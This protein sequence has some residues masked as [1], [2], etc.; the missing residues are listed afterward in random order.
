[1]K[2]SQVSTLFSLFV[3]FWVYSPFT[4]AYT[5]KTE[6]LNQLEKLDDLELISTPEE[7]HTKLY[8]AFDSAEK[9]IHIGIFGISS[10]KMADELI[11]QIHRGIDVIIICDTY[12]TSA[13]KRLSLYD[14][15][16]KAGAQVVIASSKFSI[17][18]WKM[19]VVDEKL[20]FISTMNFI[21]LTNKMRDIGL[22]T[23]EKSVIK[24]I[25]NVFY[26]DL[27]NAKNQTQ[28]TPPLT[29]PNLVWSPVNSEQKLTDLINSADTSIEIWIENLGSIKIHEALQAA[30]Q[31]GVHVRVLTS[32][33][34]MG[35]SGVP[36]H[37]NI[38][39]LLSKGINVRGTSYPANSTSPYIHAK[40]INVDRK[41]VFIGSENYSNNSL[42]RARELGVV[43]IDEKI[44]AQLSSLFEKDWSFS[45]DIPEIPPEKCSAL[46]SDGPE[47]IM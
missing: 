6:W 34:G 19:F 39:D 7:D 26:Y 21:N 25:L 10:Q 35:M 46:S 33:C 13:P 23:T 42:N 3:A 36:A 30:S 29:Q 17:T 1:M 41:A 47:Y 9:I 18:H 14:Q 31:R 4:S 24:E 5:P 15:L 8:K 38:Q 20:A 28:I 12:C 16:S 22:F 2:L 40:S 11:K 45:I 32:I 44:E 43:F 27:E 37:K